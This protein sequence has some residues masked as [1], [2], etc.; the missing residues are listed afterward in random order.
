MESGKKQELWEKMR[1]VGKKM[2]HTTPVASFWR[3]N[4]TEDSAHPLTGGGGCGGG[5]EEEHARG[6]LSENAP[7]LQFISSRKL[8]AALWELHHYHGD[9]TV[10]VSPPPCLRR[11][12]LN[13]RRSPPPVSPHD[14]VKGS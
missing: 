5:R 1:R 9:V 12:K 10:A 3:R 14:T 13:R 2:G 4:E 6:D 8:A 7:T 11:L